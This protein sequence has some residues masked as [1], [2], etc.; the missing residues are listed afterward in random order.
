MNEDEKLGRFTEPISARFPTHIDFLI[1]EKAHERNVKKS[2][3][4]R[5]IVIKYFDKE[6]QDPELIYASLN[7]AKEKI[8]FLENK[9][10][11]ISV[12]LLE[13]IKK[14]IHL[15][16]NR[17]AIPDEIADI[18]YEKFIEGVEAQLKNGHSGMLESMVLDIYQRNG[19]N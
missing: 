9:V 11:L 10:D 2:V 7:D 14:L 18:E 4:M 13:Q 8:R 16:P 6:I 5:D 17:S 3:V 12:L 1:S 19:G 15:L